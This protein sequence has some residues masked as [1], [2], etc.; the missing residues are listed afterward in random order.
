M[1]LRCWPDNGAGGAEANTLFF[2]SGIND[3]NDGPVRK[4]H[5]RDWP[6]KGTAE[7]RWGRSWSMRP[8]AD[9]L[10]TAESALPAHQLRDLND[11]AA[12]VVHHCDFGGGHLGWWLGERGAAR[13]HP[14]VIGLHVVGEEHGRGLALLQH[15]L[16]VS[17]GRRLVVERQLQLSAVRVFW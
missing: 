11:I 16:L 5:G 10:P 1:S 17:L 15:R 3:E 14:L 7:G 9:P 13:F 8:K 4:S 6:L 2:A 12:G